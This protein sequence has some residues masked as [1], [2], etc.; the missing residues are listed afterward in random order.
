MCQ[1]QAAECAVEREAYTE[2][3]RGWA[4]HRKA[5]EERVA[6]EKG[7]CTLHTGAFLGC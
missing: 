4:D 6:D 2:L 3:E 1:A 7:V 5:L